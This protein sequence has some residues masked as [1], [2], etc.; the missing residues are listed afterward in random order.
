MKTQQPVIQTLNQG[1]HRARHR[2]LHRFLDELVADFIDHT[3]GMPSKTNLMD[4]M[5]WSHE[6]TVSP[7]EKKALKKKPSERVVKVV[8]EGMGTCINADLVVDDKFICV[9][10]A[11]SP[12][13]NEMTDQIVKLAKKH[14]EKKCN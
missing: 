13:A 1:E 2:M 8:Y 12:D 3:H 14:L 5:K 4:F 11:H 9:I 6:Q 10:A 7:T